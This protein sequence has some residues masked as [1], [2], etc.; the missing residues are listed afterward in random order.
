M[1]YGQEETV[2]A[3]QLSKLER[4]TISSKGNTNMVWMKSGEHKLGPCEMSN[5]DT[6]EV[7]R[8]LAMYEDLNEESLFE[9]TKSKLVSVFVGIIVIVI[10]LIVL[11]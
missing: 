4:M 8:Q 6:G 1:K 9:V 7:L 2:R 5:H 10:A 11:L 3:I